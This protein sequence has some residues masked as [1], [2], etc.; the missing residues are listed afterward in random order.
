MQVG[1][2]ERETARGTQ[3][4]FVSS[5]KLSKCDVDV[6]CNRSRDIVECLAAK[7]REMEELSPYGGTSGTCERGDGQSFHLT[8]SSIPKV[9]CCFSIFVYQHV[10]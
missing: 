2:R 5:A 1:V 3:C 7:G 9:R 6:I 10:R 4:S 8:R